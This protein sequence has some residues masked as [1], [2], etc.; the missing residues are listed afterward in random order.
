M[1]RKALTLGAVIALFACGTA[2]AAD[3]YRVQ[4]GGNQDWGPQSGGLDETSPTKLDK[5][6][7]M[8]DNSNVVGTADY[9]VQSGPG[10]ARA[11]M[12][13][14]FTVPS[15]LA[16]PFNPSVQAVST[17]ELTIDGPGFEFNTSINLHVDGIID[18]MVCGGGSNCGALS[19]FIFA[20]A[21]TTA[22]AGSEFTS[23]GPGRE[24]ELGLTVDPV[25][26][27]FH[28]H[29]DVTSREF[30]VRVGS[31]IPIGIVLNLS[32]RFNGNAA[33]STFGGKFEVSFAPDGPVLNDLPPGHT[34]SGAGVVN[35]RWDDP[36]ANNTVVSDCNDPALA[37]L[38]AIPG[39]L[40]LRCNGATFPQ[41]THIGGDLEIDGDHAPHVA[42][43]GPVLVDGSV[44]VVGNDGG[45][46]LD[47]GD[48]SVGGAIDV[49]GNGGDLTVDVGS[50]GEAIDV[51][52]NSGDLTIDTGSVGEAIDVSGNSGDLTIVP[53]STSGDLDISDN[54]GTDVINV[55]DGQVGGDLTITDNGTAVVNANDSLTVSG[56][57]EI[58]SQDTVTATTA[59]GTTDVTV[60][61]GTAAMHV[62]LP[63]GAF[64]QPVAFTISGRGNGP[65]EGQVDPLAGYTFSFAVPTLDADA[66]LA[67]T[68]DLAA[69]DAT[70]RTA[71]LDGIAT[72]SATIVTKA[73][74]PGSV[75]SAFPRCTGTQ[76]PAANGCVAVSLSPAAQPTVA[77]FEGIAG[78]FSTWAVA[79][80]HRP[81][82]PTGSTVT[83]AQIRAL[84][85]TEITPH[86][87]AARIRALRKH[88]YRL[89]F[90]A[91][92]AGTAKVRWVRKR[93]GHKPVLIASGRH[94]FAAAGSATIKIKLTKAG[95]R[96]LRH[97]RRLRLTAMGTFTPAGA[98]PV[99]ASRRFTLRR[100]GI[101]A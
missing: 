58:E 7:Q 73:D 91:L 68:V 5:T 11:S 89:A 76:T 24:N 88:G 23:V 67:F 29:G 97:A 38:T 22:G 44:R 31:P 78:H 16:Y 52:G 33:Q 9:H 17:T 93:K 85:R 4:I 6:G 54:S 87:K 25:P 83:A 63:D 70:T 55:G 86:G 49:S 13:G 37:Q 56:D 14:E 60:L 62:T 28:V 10:I 19:A 59:D 45:G 61:G 95:R 15:N 72:G 100:S 18:S 81:K 32:G 35:N 47:L 46:D 48:T 80:V 66:R 90:R 42:F 101:P 79:L 8:T 71:L 3:S 36:F 84:L 77:S 51:S 64:D 99:T 96:Q 39:N 75:Y 74:A 57:A 94:T 65:A 27:G 98:A 1:T 21:S 43:P 82:P 69:L 50:V 40:V 12:S 26:G 2:Q 41:L 92:T 20:P 53:G 34:V 30:G